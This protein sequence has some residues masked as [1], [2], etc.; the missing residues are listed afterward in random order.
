MDPAREV[1]ATVCWSE[2]H[3][4][5]E[6]EP[7]DR[8]RRFQVL[9]NLEA[10]A[11]TYPAIDA[12]SRSLAARRLPPGL[13]FLQLHPVGVSTAADGI[14]IAPTCLSWSGGI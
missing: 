4:D 8:L 3:A 1:P 10:F 7:V 5:R 11:A 6:I 12:V 9:W 13:Q 2:A 14:A